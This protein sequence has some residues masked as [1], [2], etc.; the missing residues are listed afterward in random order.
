[1]SQIKA[2]MTGTASTESAKVLDI[3]N[4]RGGDS[5]TNRPI[6]PGNDQE[7]R[8]YKTQREK[9]NAVIEEIEA[10]GARSSKPRG[11]PLQKYPNC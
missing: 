1:M 3:Y 7:D 4:R 6:L 10:A 8:V 2:G 5:R 9:Y 11:Q